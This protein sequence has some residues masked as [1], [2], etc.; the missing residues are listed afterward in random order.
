MADYVASTSGMLK[1]AKE[2]PKTEF[3]VATEVGLT[4]LMRIRMPQK[5]FHEALPGAVCIQMKKTTLDLVL[6]SSLYG[7]SIFPRSSI[8]IG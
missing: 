8:V 7:Y 6:N 2:S 1:Y 3:I 5:I 4:E